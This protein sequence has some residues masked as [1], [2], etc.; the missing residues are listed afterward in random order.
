MRYFIMLCFLVLFS[1]VPDSPK[2][3]APDEPSGGVGVVWLNGTRA[4]CL[5][6]PLRDISKMGYEV[7]CPESENTGSGKECLEEVD[8]LVKDGISK[9]G[10]IGHSQGGG[11]AFVCAARAE[12]KY[13]SVKF[14]V[15]GVEPAHGYKFRDWKPFYRDLKSP[16]FQW[17]GTKDTLVTKSWTERGY[18]LLTGE[19][20]LYSAV[21]AR[22]VPVPSRWIRD[23]IIFFDWKLKGSKTEQDFKSLPNSPQWERG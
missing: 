1:C 11:G 17:W 12:K 15:I 2:P 10:I 20:Y 18:K 14:A 23:S 8:D 16:S 19:K 3:D 5:N 6:Y 22:H 4:R 13:P 21:G 9:I 7:K